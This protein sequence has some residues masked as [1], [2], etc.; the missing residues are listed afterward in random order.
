MQSTSAPARVRC[1][2]PALLLATVGLAGCPSTTPERTP[3]DGPPAP[4]VQRVNCPKV[5]AGEVTEITV[6]ASTGEYAYS[7]MSMKIKSGDVV[8]FRSGAE[9][10]TLSTPPGLFDT[11]RGQTECYKFNSKETHN[12]MCGAHGFAGKIIVE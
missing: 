11:E 2:L 7:P 3:P 6:N 8:R 9:H 10:F 5:V 4:R 1:A 12:F